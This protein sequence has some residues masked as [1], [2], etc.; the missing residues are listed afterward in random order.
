MHSYLPTHSWHRCSLAAA[1]ILSL[2]ALAPAANAAITRPAGSAHATSAHTRSIQP[3]YTCP[4]RH[5]CVFHGTSFNGYHHAYAT[6]SN[7]NK[8][9]SLTASPGNFSL[10]WGSVNNNSGS[11]VRFEN[12]SGDWECIFPHIKAS[13]G[14]HVLANATRHYRYMYIE[15]GNTECSAN[16]HRP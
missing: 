12:T 7:K 8:W 1:S 15:Y 6:T 4:S 3:D 5:V 10:P 2:A 16:P 14:N 9:I 13:V 11:S